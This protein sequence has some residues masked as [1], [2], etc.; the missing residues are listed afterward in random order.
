MLTTIVALHWADV[1]N[2][3]CCLPNEAVSEGITARFIRAEGADTLNTSY[4]KALKLDT[5]R[6]AVSLDVAEL[7]ILSQIKT[8]MAPDA[9]DII[10]QL[11][12]LN[13]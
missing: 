12:M 10:P 11:Y 7:G 5:Q 6:F 9:V 8:L 13:M 3:Y 1:G 4:R 2:G